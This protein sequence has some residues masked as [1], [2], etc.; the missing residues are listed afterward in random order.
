ML[1]QTL[2]SRCFR[3]D[4]VHLRKP[5]G[6]FTAKECADCII[7]ALTFLPEE[8]NKEVYEVIIKQNSE[9]SNKFV[10]LQTV[11]YWKGQ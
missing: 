4:I 10:E 7:K 1:D 6:S 9:A 11:I 5:E 8:D 3:W 2:M